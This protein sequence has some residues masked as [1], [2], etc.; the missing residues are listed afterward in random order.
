MVLVDDAMVNMA[1]PVKSKLET[2]FW[3]KAKEADKVGMESHETPK[4]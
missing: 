1:S 2:C 3:L 4:G